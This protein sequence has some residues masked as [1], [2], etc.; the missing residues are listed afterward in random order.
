MLREKIR[1]FSICDF[2]RENT[3]VCLYGGHRYCFWWLL[4]LYFQGLSRN[5][6]HHRVVPDEV[7]PQAMRVAEKV[8][9]FLLSVK[10]EPC[11]WDSQKL[12]EKDSMPNLKSY[13]LRRCPYN[14]ILYKVGMSLC[15]QSLQQILE[16]ATILDSELVRGFKTPSPFPLI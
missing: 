3:L 2:S 4:Y 12:S 9:I 5:L 7:K 8:S 13:R 15:S 16:F 6:N 14:I 10:V 11:F 1:Q